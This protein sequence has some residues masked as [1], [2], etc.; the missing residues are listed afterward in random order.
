L[1]DILTVFAK[2]DNDK[3]LSC[4]LVERN[5]PGVTFGAEEH[6]MGIK[7]SSTVQIFFNDCK[8][9]VENM[10]GKRGEG[11]RIALN[12]LHIGR[13][14]LGANVIGS[15]KRAINHSVQYANERKQ[16]GQ[17]ISNFGAI[18]YKLAEQVIVVLPMNRLFSNICLC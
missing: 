9:P 7:G 16:F 11:F 15:I 13:I 4:F 8:I 6:K 3:I 18:K 17:L 5:T 14:K 10:I 1:P 2:V 12:I